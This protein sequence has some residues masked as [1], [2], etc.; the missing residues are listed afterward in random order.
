MEQ[1]SV[2]LG[3]ATQEARAALNSL[4]I[5]TTEGNDLAEALRQAT[6]E[7]RMQSPVEVS[8]S[9]VGNAKQVHPV[10]RDEVY[11]IAYEAIRNACMHS[12]GSRLEVGL[13]YTQ[14]LAVRVSDNGIG[15]DPSVADRSKDGHYGLQGMR[16]RAAR[17]G[18]TLTI[19]SSADSGTEITIVVPGAIVYRKAGGTPSAKIKAILRRAGRTFDPD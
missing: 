1:L 7:C 15:I 4:R 8:F 18:G 19:V 11:R 13:K 9:V 2:W 17:I 14:D 3:R 16:E 10:V 12:R 6:E 5:S